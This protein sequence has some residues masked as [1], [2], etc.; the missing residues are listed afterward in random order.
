M[1]LNITPIVTQL[2]TRIAAS[3][4]TSNISDLITLVRLAQDYNNYNMVVVQS[5]GDL[6][7]V[8]SSTIG[9]V[10]YVR[11]T[12]DD[13]HGSFYV[14]HRGSW[15]TI[16]LNAD[17][18][19]LNP[20]EPPE[21]Q[22]DAL[23]QGTSY[24]YVA[25]GYY[26]PS[27]PNS[28]N[29]IQ[30][31]SYTSNGNSVSVGTIA[32]AWFNNFGATSVLAGYVFGGDNAGPVGTLGAVDKFPFATDTSSGLTLDLSSIGRPKNQV[33]SSN[34]GAFMAGTSNPAPINTENII[35]F[36]FA[37]DG[38]TQ[39]V[40]VVSDGTLQLA[41][42][43]GSSSSTH[44]YMTAG[45]YT[46]PNTYITAIRRFPFATT[47]TVQVMSAVMV[48][49][50]AQGRATQSTTHGYQF[51]GSSPALFNSSSIQ[52]FSFAS[53]TN[54]VQIGTMFTA[55]AI[56]STSASTTKAYSAGGMNSSNAV[57]SN[58]IQSVPFATDTNASDVGDLL[59]VLR[60]ASGHQY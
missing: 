47:T 1:P 45:R 36:S 41:L 12:K 28:T 13:S 59:T 54:A 55:L 52:K 22:L 32:N 44:G 9:D 16:N 34:L 37:N 53:D 26:Q 21:P 23:L 19:E 6:P 38:V 33:M 51:G 25:G 18:D 50:A 56:Q 42:A 49:N 14:G 4:S 60:A 20:I 43:S 11:D 40:G 58:V 15:M 2:E 7:P 17:S 35:R 3:N 10:F 39:Q 46:P 27:A 30:K 5:K 48:N 29:V 57:N 24:G 31:Y 8:D